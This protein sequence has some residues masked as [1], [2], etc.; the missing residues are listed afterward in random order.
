MQARIHAVLYQPTDREY[1]DNLEDFIREPLAAA[2][3]IEEI[4][5]RGDAKAG[6]HP[7]RQLNFLLLEWLD[8]VGSLGYRTHPG[9]FG[10]QLILA[11]LDPVL[12]TAGLELRLGDQAV[13]RLT[14]PRTG[15]SR[16]EIAQGK[17]IADIS[18]GI[19]WLAQVKAGGRIQVGDPVRVEAGA[20]QP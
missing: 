13:I 12:L 9:A 5:I 10:E 15:C 2:E 17:S 4:G 11:G 19:G 3:L 14:K 7:E 8:Q 6:H 20:N 1:G 18:G 16:L